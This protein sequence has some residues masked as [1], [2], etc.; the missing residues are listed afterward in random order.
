[1]R[2]KHSTTKRLENWS[3]YMRNRIIRGW[4]KRELFI[5]IKSVAGWGRIPSTSLR[6]QLMHGGEHCNNNRSFLYS[7]IL[8]RKDCALHIVF[9]ATINRLIILPLFSAWW[10]FSYFCNPPNSD[11]DYRIFNMHT[12]SFLCMRIHMARGWAFWQRVSIIIFDSETHKIFFGSR[13]DSNLGPV[14]L[15]SVALSSE[16]PHVIAKFLKI[17]SRK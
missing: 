4:V 3:T 5:E 17:V 11:I 2:G 12:W 8:H 16:S 14:N 10:V 7:T 13:Q 15:E 1:M 9:V 6:C